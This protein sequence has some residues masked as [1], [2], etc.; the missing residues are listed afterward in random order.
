MSS[1]S[2]TRHVSKHRHSMY[3]NIDTTCIKTSTQ[4]VSKHRHNLYQKIDTPL[5]KKS[6]IQ[7][8]HFSKKSIGV[9]DENYGIEIEAK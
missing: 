1:N 2:G 8:T 5:R 7:S 3:Q 9:D 4:H 6:H